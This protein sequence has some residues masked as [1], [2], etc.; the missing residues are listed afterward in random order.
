VSDQQKGALGVMPP[1]RKPLDDGGPAFPSA[2]DVDRAE[3][4]TWETHHPTLGLSKLDYFAAEAMKALIMT[5]TRQ[6]D[7]PALAYQHAS[8]M[9]LHRKALEQ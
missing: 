1:I 4:G 9:L 8:R 3:N 6:R 7:I 2:R 5:G